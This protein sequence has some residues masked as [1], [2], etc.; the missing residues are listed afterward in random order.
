MAI[1]PD[2]GDLLSHA[3][4]LRGL[5]THLLRDDD[6]DD[7]LQETW[8]AAL[9]SPPAGDPEQARPW[10][11]QV[12]RN[13]ARRRWHRTAAR[14]AREQAV[15]VADQT[16][17]APDVLLERAQLQRSLADHVLA[18]DEPYRTVILLRYYEGQSAADIARAQGLPAGTV[19][20]R[21]KEAIERLR[22]RLD[23]QHHGDRG[24]WRAM[25]VPFAIAL[26]PAVPGTLLR[27]ALGGKLALAGAVAALLVLLAVGGR[28]GTGGA[29]RSRQARTLPPP[30]RVLLPEGGK[31]AGGIEGVVLDPR[32]RPAGG[33][34]VT[35]AREPL[36]G[37]LL[38]RGS[39]GVA[40]ADAAG[41]FAFTGAWVG[42]CQVS[43]TLP[44]FRAA[45]SRPFP[46]ASGQR[47]QLTLK[48]GAGGAT[49][50]GRILDEEGSPIPGAAVTAALGYPWTFNAGAVHVRRQFRAIAD[51][52][53]RYQLTLEP[54]EY[55]LR[56]EAGG[57][58]SVETT[59]AIT[60]AVTRDVR[61]AP[62]A[63]L[64]GQVVDREGQ[65]VPQADVMI[66]SGIR[67]QAD[68]RSAR[69]DDEGRFV[70]DDA[71]AGEYEV[72]ARARARNLHG[73]VP[74]VIAV[75]M[76]AREGI[77][78]VVGPGLT[79]TGRVVDEAGRGLAEI[80]I[81]LSGVDLSLAARDR[82]VSEAAGRFSVGVPGPG[83]YR[84]AAQGTAAGPDAELSITVGPEGAHE[85]RLVVASRPEIGVMR[86]RVLG[87]AGAAVGGALVRVET[88]GRASGGLL[89]AAESDDE[90]AFRVERLPAA[91]L[92]LVA[93]HPVE[94][95]AEV[96]LDPPGSG[97]RPSLTVRL[98]AGA[99]IR[100]VVRFEDGGPAPG[101]SVAAT[102]Q[103]GT[104]IYDST[105]TGADGR[106]EIRS[107]AAGRYTVR[108]T[109]KIGPNNLWTSR[110]RPELKLVDVASGETSADVSLT[111]K[112]GGKTIAGVVL[113]PDG[114]PAAGTLIVANRE[115]NGSSWKP[116]AQHVEH[117]TT[118]GEDGHW[119]L[120]DVEDDTFALW[121]IR[122]D[123]ADAELAGVKAGRSDVR[124]AF[125]AP[126][127]IAGVVVD[128]AGK[129]VADFHLGVVPA[130]VPSETPAR[131]SRRS[132]ASQSPPR[133]M[134]DPGGAFSVDGLLADTYDVHVTTAEGGGGTSQSITVVAGE[135]KTGL[136]LVLQP[137][138]KARGKVI[139]LDT[140][141]PVPGIHVRTRAAGRWL[142][143]K[144]A[145]DGSY[146]L[147]GLLPGQE[148]SIETQLSELTELVPE[149]LTT[150]VPRETPI[151]DLGTFRLISGDWRARER[152]GAT[153][154]L[155][156]LPKDGRPTVVNVRPDLP[157]A[158][159]GIAE[160]EVVVAVNGREVRGLGAGAV[161]YLLRE[162]P[163][164]KLSVTLETPAGKARTVVVTTVK[165]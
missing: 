3:H 34:L 130:Q 121:A 109:R 101:I 8:M 81:G 61:L 88:P 29:S 38:R 96:N 147:A 102:R 12:L 10:L 115:E 55:A 26:A 36:P 113:L 89:A 142:E 162:P 148:I 120:D 84:L 143:G 76:Q 16:A 103:E 63:R 72:F 99:R 47:Q 125:P 149:Y 23:Q 161:S 46:L 6:P 80:P 140:G 5:A 97:D 45:V 13:F 137:A 116:F 164:S 2:I 7:V 135:Q 31:A 163:G 65:P 33:A 117:R 112:R 86:G 37:E 59:V 4:W 139:R 91:P 1:E 110:E 51:Q 49:L 90:G 155:R 108:A 95:I 131:R 22:G 151:V 133:R 57:Y 54:R 160:G 150:V 78:V 83:R 165:Q 48:L 9:R 25:L 136:R 94:G 30:A 159:A 118:A 60:T 98:E 127:R 144:T 40:T 77:R 44:G 74:R 156:L 128:T 145:A 67:G 58:A 119:K 92:R 124:L 52:A 152:S 68:P 41:R 122:P 154:G 19:R 11:A 134:H 111:L 66:W 105:T 123:F 157:G 71:A 50:T 93:W 69:T 20:W 153:V 70:I 43:A 141:A 35:L 114:Q 132:D 104:V 75:S 18:L 62:A 82:A 39:L 73:S 32:G 138:V 85:L 28:S 53:G 27:L 106:F 126:A 107:L 129:P 42:E 17:P 15:A 158:R 14:Q 146:E 21:L 56:V 100:G 79:V 87:A 24:R 64:A